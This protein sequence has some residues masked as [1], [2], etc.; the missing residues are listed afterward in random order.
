M[1]EHSSAPNSTLRQWLTD[2]TLHDAAGDRLYAQGRDLLAHG[3][4][5]SVRELEDTL[6]GR[7]DSGMLEPYEVRISATGEDEVFDCECEGFFNEFVCEHV[8]AVGLAWLQQTRAAP[9]QK[10]P[11]KAS[12]SGRP[13]TDE[14]LRAWVDGHQ[15]SYAGNASVWELQPYLPASL[16]QH[17]ALHA[18]SDTRVAALLTHGAGRGYVNPRNLAALQEAAWT[19]L[20]K[21]AE[22]V[23][24]GL[25]QE[26]AAA[27][28]PPPTDAR[29]V[30]LVEALQRERERVRAHV[31]PR[32]LEVTPAVYLQESPLRLF[33]SEA[34]PVKA[35][36]EATHHGFK[37]VALEPQA[38][39]EARPGLSCP[40][41]RGSEAR[42]VHALTALD[43][44]LDALSRKSS[45]EFNTQ[46]AEQ[47]FVVPGQRILAALEAASLSAQAPTVPALTGHVT[48]RLEGASTRAFILRPYVHRL[49]KKGTLSRGTQ[50]SWRDRNEVRALLTLPGEHEALS[51]IDAGSALASAGYSYMSSSGGGSWAL[52]LQALRALAH[53]PRLRLAE[54]PDVPLQVRESPLGFTFEEDADGVLRVRPSIEGMPIR[55]EDLCP[56]TREP[57][58]PHPWLLV[59]QEVPRVTL[60]TV[61]PEA[62]VLLS[63]LREFGSRLPASA[64]DSLLTSLAGLEARFPLSLPESL[65]GAELAPAPGLLVRLRAVGDE[66]LE[67]VVLVR[68]LPEAPPQPPGEGP[69][70]VRG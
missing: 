18:F 27:P 17:G 20:R 2:A 10:R 38:L 47:L 66:A 35:P 4:V 16:R 15:V 34:G 56:P 9:R 63:T 68:P 29:L 62:R 45:A 65:E 54:R 31:P 37:G 13:T 5:L 7:V 69:P 42:C 52:L 21:E 48:F 30:P 25:A 49:T 26:Q 53:S 64:H 33:V 67:G 22:R 11:P 43:A 46:L 40:C 1:L 32:A 70:V 36:F 28:R 12:P 44:V 23:R 6:E 57:L 19:F 39:L 58:A 3:D 51:L 24:L 41:S 8:V 60:V 50:L 14:A 59:E 55:A 61:P